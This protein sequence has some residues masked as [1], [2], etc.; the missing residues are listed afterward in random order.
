MNVLFIDWPCFG[1]FDAISA[2]KEMGYQIILF[3]HEDYQERISPNFDKAFDEAVNAQ[4][5]RFCFSFNYYPV[6]SE[7]CRR[8]ELPYVSL[9]YD[10]PHVPL[11]SYTM[12]YPTNH[13]FLFDRQEYLK[14]R[15]MG[16]PTVYYSP[17]PVNASAIDQCAKGIFDRKKCTCDI[18]FVGSLYNEDHNLYDRLADVND[19]T[20][21]YLNAV[22]EAQLKIYG[23]NFLE[24]V[25]TGDILAE[26]LR[27]CPYANDQYGVETPE[28]IYANYFLGRKI[29]SLER[30]RLLTAIGKRF[31]RQLKLFTINQKFQIPNVQNMG[32]ANYDTEMLPVFANSKI[33]LNITLK[34]IQSGIPLRAMDIMGAGGFLLTNFQADFLDYF[35]PDEDFVYFN[36]LD[37]LLDKIEYYLSHSKERQEIARNGRQKVKEHHS[38][39]KCFEHILSIAHIDTE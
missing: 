9:V 35:V 25:L 37:D 3:G 34:S 16:I 4:K 19:Y 2:L 12:I 22:I 23:Y 7:G 13:V 6:V 20:R 33:N 39:K 14:L 8:N 38:F 27:V 21:G 5:F 10:S 26:L 30:I 11:Y 29:T 15:N 28:Y 24:E 18:S 17:L 31:P 36:D 1:K 32:T